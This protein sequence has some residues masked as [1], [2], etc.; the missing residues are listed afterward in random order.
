MFSTKWAGNSHR[1]AIFFGFAKSTVTFRAASDKGRSTEQSHVP[2]LCSFEML[3]GNHAKPTRISV[4]SC[5]FISVEGEQ[6]I[7]YM[8]AC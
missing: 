5:Q 4:T 7:R 1:N 8:L 6:T 3:Y 2:M